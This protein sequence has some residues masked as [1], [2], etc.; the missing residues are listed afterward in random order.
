MWT[1]LIGKKILRVESRE[2]DEDGDDERV[3][4]VFRFHLDDGST[5]DFITNCGDVSCYGTLYP[6]TSGCSVDKLNANGL[7]IGEK[8]IGPKETWG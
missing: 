3:Q 4:T 8:W 6:L 2:V 5:Y 1:P 7:F